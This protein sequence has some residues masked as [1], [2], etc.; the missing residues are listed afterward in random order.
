MDTPHPADLGRA[1]GTIAL[2]LQR[3]GTAPG[4]DD[5]GLGVAL[6]IVT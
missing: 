5:E 6:D 1:S 4:K 3:Q 2:K